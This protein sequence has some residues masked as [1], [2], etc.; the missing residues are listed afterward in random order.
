[1]VALL[2]NSMKPPYFLI[3]EAL[4]TTFDNVAVAAGAAPDAAP[5]PAAT[6]APLAASEPAHRSTGM[7]V[8]GIVLT[9]MGS[10]ALLGGVGITV[11]SVERATE[12]IGSEE[13][14]E[15]F[16]ALRPP[17]VGA[18]TSPAEEVSPR[19]TCAHVKPFGSGPAPENSRKFRR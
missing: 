11:D 3:F 16:G 4:L 13:I 2:S 1:V 7:T 6:P 15:R 9:S 8:T 5:L 10:L 19:T 12:L 14:G 17:P 18:S